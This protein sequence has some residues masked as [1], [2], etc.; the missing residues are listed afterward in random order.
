MAVTM[1]N[2]DDGTTNVDFAIN[3]NT[4]KYPGM[5]ASLTQAA[6]TAP[7]GQN[8]IFQGVNQLPTMSF[9]G[10][11]RTEAWYDTL[12]TWANKGGVL[13]LTDD[14]GESFNIVIRSLT[15]TR[16]RRVNPWRFDYEI[17]AV[18]VG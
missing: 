10:V 15:W 16:I 17:E 11:V 12:N 18:V 1:W 4:A 7:D 3:P 8:V 5:T 9:S 2:L 13:L 6:T 14:L